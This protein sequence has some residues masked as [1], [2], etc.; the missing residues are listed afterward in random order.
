MANQHNLENISFANLV[1]LCSNNGSI[2]DCLVSNNIISRQKPCKCGHHMNIIK[3]KRNKDGREY[4][5][6]KC[7]T[8]RS[9]R[10]ETGFGRWKLPLSTLL[11]IV[12]C[13]AHD[14]NIY[15]TCRLVPRVCRR[16]CNRIYKWLRKLARQYQ[17]ENI[18]EIG[19]KH[20]IK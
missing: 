10:G 6:P 9:L 18:K 12:W 1:I 11:C 20:A 17:R 14:Y 5:C 3:T 7:K 4:K 16:S 15:E 2:V 13:W 8:C 19:I